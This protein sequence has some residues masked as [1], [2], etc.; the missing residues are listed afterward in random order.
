MLTLQTHK[1]N[2]L[3]TQAGDDNAKFGRP[4]HNFELLRGKF[5]IN[6]NQNLKDHEKV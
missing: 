5:N 6:L 2:S 1:K 3:V 4:A